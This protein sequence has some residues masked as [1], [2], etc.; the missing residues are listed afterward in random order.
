MVVAVIERSYWMNLRDIKIKRRS[1]PFMSLILRWPH[2][3]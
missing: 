3:P 2:P 1:R